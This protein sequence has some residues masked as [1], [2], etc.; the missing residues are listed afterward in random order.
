MDSH[1]YLYIDGSAVVSVKDLWPDGDAPEQPTE[2]DIRDA[3]SEFSIEDLIQR[4]VPDLTYDV[5][6]SR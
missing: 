2:D 6:V 4:W 5:S 1:F 3:L